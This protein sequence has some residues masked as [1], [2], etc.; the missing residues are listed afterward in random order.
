MIPSN[1][2]NVRTFADGEYI[3]R[4]GDE[5]Q[6]MFVVQ[7]GEVIISRNSA[8]GTVVFATLKR[9]DFL[10]EMSLLES[11]PRNADARAKG[12]TTLLAIQAGGFLLKIR[13]DPTFAFELMQAL[14]RRIRHTN[15]RLIGEL[16]NG[17]LSER[18]LK[19]ILSESGS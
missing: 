16:Q 18:E 15:E 10:G 7:S 4:E 5:T 2:E 13:R 17:A 1:P 14:S 11:M 12:K 6:Q 19:K 3:F 8:S 9:G